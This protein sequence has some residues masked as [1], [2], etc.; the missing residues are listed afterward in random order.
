MGRDRVPDR[1]RPAL[2]VEDALMFALLSIGA[3]VVNIAAAAT[4]VLVAV[5][6]GWDV[7]QAG[8]DELQRRKSV[9][10]DP[11]GRG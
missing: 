7:W 6:H 8:R 1:R 2:V 10:G 3:R 9:D 4:T 5:K 11:G